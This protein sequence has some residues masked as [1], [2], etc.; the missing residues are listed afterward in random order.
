MSSIS[1]ELAGIQVLTAA[2]GIAYENS[3]KRW[4]KNAEQRADYVAFPASAEDVSKAVSSFFVSWF[5]ILNI[6]LIGAFTYLSQILYATHNN[7]EL[8]IKCGGHSN[9]GASSA[10]AGGLVLDLAK[11]NSVHVDTELRLLKVG[12]GALWA[13]VDVAAGKYGLATVGGTINHTGAWN[14]S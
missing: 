12:G 2:D 4:S 14:F 8:A 9:S 6:C 3:L 5:P 11:L 10:G 1:S 13:D 7:I